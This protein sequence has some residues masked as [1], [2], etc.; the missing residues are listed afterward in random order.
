MAFHLILLLYLGSALALSA[1][2]PRQAQSVTAPVDGRLEVP[3]KGTERLPS[4]RGVAILQ[5]HPNNTGITVALHGMRPARLF[6]GDLNTYVVW[7]IEPDGTT[8]N[9][10]EMVLNGRHSE[11]TISARSD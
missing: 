10:G 3:L 7:L 2:N 11:L 1:G 5:S 6:G 4:G 8:H 9:A